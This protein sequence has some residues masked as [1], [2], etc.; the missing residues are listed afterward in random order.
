MHLFYIGVEWSNNQEVTMRHIFVAS[1]TAAA[2]IIIPAI[3]SAHVTVRP[4]S[5]GIGAFQTFTVGVP[6]EKDQPTIGLKLLIPAGLQEVVPT[7]KAGWTIDTKKSGD[8]V[9]E[10]DWTGGSI[11]AE[12]RDDFSFSAQAPAKPTDIDWKAYQMYQDGS[13]I[14]LDM[15]PS[16]SMAEASS[17]GPYSVTNVVDDLTASSMTTKTNNNVFIGAYAVG[18]IAFITA[19]VGIAF[20]R[21]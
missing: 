15:T 16:S 2:I 21:S 8:A 18:F 13:I 12:R 6:V 17:T 10:I 3:A 5:V 9:T 11:P 7:V 14:S 4:S 1:I 20:K 19:V